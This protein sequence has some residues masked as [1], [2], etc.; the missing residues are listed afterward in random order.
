[1]CG[2]FAIY[3]NKCIHINELISI[4]AQLNHRGKD[5]MVLLLLRKIIKKIYKSSHLLRIIMKMN[6]IILKLV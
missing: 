2:I 1:M 5:S 3:S 4:L 6:V